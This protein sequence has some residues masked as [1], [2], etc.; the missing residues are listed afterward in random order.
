MGKVV[1]YLKL[2]LSIF[3]LEFLEPVS[4]PFLANYFEL[5]KLIQINAKPYY[6]SGR[7][8]YVSSRA[9][10]RASA[11]P[12]AR[13]YAL[14]A[15]ANRSALPVSGTAARHCA[16]AHLSDAS[17]PSLFSPATRARRTSPGNA[18]LGPLLGAVH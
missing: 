7:P 13:V 2:F 4:S 15:P 12:H 6:A 16:A 10:P 18:T 3:Y 8:V 17:L 14:P 5:F 9:R 11:Q 1:P